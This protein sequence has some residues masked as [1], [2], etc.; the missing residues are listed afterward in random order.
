MKAATTTSKEDYLKA[1]LEAAAEGQTVIPALIAHRLGVSPPAVTMALKRLRR[2]GLVEPD[3]DGTVRLSASGHATAYGTAMRHHLIERM[4]SEIFHMPWHQIHEEAE[5]L[6]HAVSPAFEA[7]LRQ[8]L[9]EAGTCPHGNGVLP[10]PSAVRVERG[11]LRL[12]EAA[13][14]RAY[15]AVNLVVVS[16]EE[17]DPELLAYL[18]EAGVG[19]GVRLSVMVRNY[20][21]TVAIQ[22]DACTA[23]LGQA[24]AGAV[25][26]RRATEPGPG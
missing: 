5:R 11:E 2:D 7:C 18:H 17:R 23:T 4:L 22:M 24:A 20:D 15:H 10:T 25:W 1:I 6:E 13:S 14:Q 21:Q 16:L 12:S 8:K 3:S 19:L 26:V 9:G